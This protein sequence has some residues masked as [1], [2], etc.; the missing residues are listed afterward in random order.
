MHPERAGSALELAFPS[1][2]VVFVITSRS[3]DVLS[4]ATF[5]AGLLG[6][7]FLLLTSFALTGCRPPHSGSIGEGYVAPQTLNLRS[8]LT[9]KNT[10]SV[11]L[12]HGDPVD[13]IDVRRRFVKVRT[14]AGEEGWVDAT[15]L[16]SPEQMS[17][18]REDEIKAKALPSQGSATVYESLN[19][20]ID[21]NR[22][23]PA[24]AK[25]QEGQYVSVLA[26]RLSPKV[27][28][29][30]SPPALIHE[31]P[32]SE[33]RRD[34]R[35]KQRSTKGPPP[36]APPKAPQHWEAL[37]TERIEGSESTADAKARR[38]SE[39]A[40][41]KLDESKKPVA[42]EDW[43]LVRTKDQQI[44]WV[45]TRNLTM[46]IP[47]EVAQYAG[48][49]RITSYF[50]LGE[51][52][53]EEKGAKHNWLWTTASEQITYDFDAWRVFLWNRRRHRY[54]TSYR[55]RG[56]EGYYPVRVDPPDPNAFGR[57]F[58][59][60]TKDEDG[61]FRIRDYGFDGTR[62]HLMSTEDYH[63]S[64]SAPAKPAANLDTTKLEGKMPRGGWFRQKWNT[65]TGRFKRSS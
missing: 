22:Q 30:L 11:T 13:I 46:G 32:Q 38:E 55:K 57:T 1:L 60:M 28:P 25:I 61:K 15:Q 40:T 29:A 2:A 18:I 56:V 41:R 14:A 35:Q 51:V 33:S 20:H 19:V 49:A 24:F 5:S 4:R 47:D 62:V 50:D 12:K 6:C 3:R 64:G 53:D 31:R 59:L 27:G 45:L 58:H 8:D 23:S 44:G 9:T 39:A 52:K 63:P 43:T 48:G 54:E 16:L 17:R 37:S 65:L 36:P 34:R 42:V 26:H 10:T 7:L 21:P